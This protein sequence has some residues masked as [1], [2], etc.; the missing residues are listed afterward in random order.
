MWSG[1]GPLHQLLYESTGY[2]PGY[3]RVS[4][5]E[6]TRIQHWLCSVQSR[7][8]IAFEELPD[9]NLLAPKQRF[10]H[11][12]H[13]VRGIERRVVFELFHTGAEPLVSVVVVI[14]DARAEDIQERK[15]FM[16]NALLDQ[17]RQMLLFSAVPAGN[18]RGSG[19]ESQRNWIH[20]RLDVS[21]GHAFRLHTETAGV[22]G[23]GVGEP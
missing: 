12:G 8:I 14:G 1:S 22:S 5:C 17:I 10:S 2:V 13:P 6:R 23:L 19:G 3:P 18:E 7:H 15:S 20:R 21:N 16:L 4:M 11:R 9:W